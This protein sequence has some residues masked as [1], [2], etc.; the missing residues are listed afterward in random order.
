MSTDLPTPPPPMSQKSCAASVGAASSHAKTSLKAHS[1][2]PGRCAPCFSRHRSV[3]SCASRP[4]STSRRSCTLGGASCPSADPPTAVALAVACASAV[5]CA[6][7]PASVFGLWIGPGPGCVGTTGFEAAH[8]IAKHGGPGRR[9][10]VTGARGDSGVG[11]RV[12]SRHTQR[13]ARM[14][15][16]ARR[17]ACLSRGWCAAQ[18][19]PCAA[20]RAVRGQTGVSQS[21][22]GDTA[23]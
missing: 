14:G 21:E 13:D 11:R 9:L 22:N 4:C 20:V 7:A 16:V 2:V 19:G 5:A 1:R 8:P 18:G 10:W 17:R 23:T 12:Q 6:P 15:P 3:K